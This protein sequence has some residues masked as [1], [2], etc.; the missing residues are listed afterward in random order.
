VWHYLARFGAPP[1]PS[2]EAVSRVQAE[3]VTF[4]GLH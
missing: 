4:H 2:G 3:K 1:R